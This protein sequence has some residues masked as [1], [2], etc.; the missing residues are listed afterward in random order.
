MKV[1]IK[2]MIV[3]LELYFGFPISKQFEKQ[4]ERKNYKMKKFIVDVIEFIWPIMRP[5]TEIKNISISECKLLDEEIEFRY[6]EDYMKNENN[7]REEVESKAKYFIIMFI[8]MTLVLAYFAIDFIFTYT[9]NIEMLRYIVIFLICL[10][11]I[12]LCRAILFAVKAVAIRNHYTSDL[13]EF[14]LSENKN[15]K[16]KLFV[17]QY[18]ALLNYQFQINKKVDNMAMVQ[19]YFERVV[20]TI[21]V[22][23]FV[24]YIIFLLSIFSVLNLN[25]NNAQNITEHKIMANYAIISAIIMITVIICFIRLNP[26]HKKTS[27][28]LSRCKG[29]DIVKNGDIDN[30][31]LC[32]YY[33]RKRRNANCIWR[34][35]GVISGILIFTE[36]VII[37]ILLVQK[38]DMFSSI[39][40]NIS[41][42]IPKIVDNNQAQIVQLVTDFTTSYA[43]EISDSLVNFHTIVL[44][45]ISVI[46]STIALKYHDIYNTYDDKIHEKKKK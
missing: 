42:N 30:D 32:S 40:D 6:L 34:I 9:F 18:N 11:I 13:S 5:S 12:Y 7:R 33:E 20:V 31:D 4:K 35:F 37:I 27:I 22:L 15:K 46:T 14:M 45:V 39:A 16:R 19:L 17:E 1:E 2:N 28:D 10:T 38:H 21:L 24:F 43:K 26:L 3:Y 29:K 36:V 23:T 41:A 25:I 44:T 8:S